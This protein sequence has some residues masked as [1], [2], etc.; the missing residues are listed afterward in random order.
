MYV[1]PWLLNPHTHL[2]EGPLIVPLVALAY[3]GGARLLGP[4]PNT[5]EGLLTGTSTIKYCRQGQQFMPTKEPIVFIPIVQLTE[6]TTFEMIDEWIACGVH[7]AKVY[8]KARTTGSHLGVTDY[9][10]IL[11][12]VRYCGEKGVR[13]H[14]HPELPLKNV[15][16]RDA[17]YLF[18]PVMDMF[19]RGTNTVLIWEHGTDARCIPYWKEWA[20]T[21]RFY[22]TITAHHLVENETTSY[23]DA[24]TACKPPP[25]TFADMHGLIALVSECHL[26]VM[27][28]GDDAPHSI[29][30]K[31]RV[32]QCACGA[33]TA[34][35]LLLL[36]AHALKELVLSDRGVVF[37]RFI[38]GNA[39]D[40]YG[41]RLDERTARL[42]DVPFHIPLEYQAGPWRIRPFWA[43]R[44]LDFSFA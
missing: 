13:V 35:F 14:F 4:M 41:L 42:D 15:D 20:K 9:F 38:N 32:G 11:P 6:D 16:N 44:T 31:H 24:A 26:W 5:R 25:K 21:G 29:E 7:D 30:D 22:L 28:G 36:Y 8:P 34:P 19:V 27:A 39:K 23:G 12:Q 1:V 17:E 43:G 3:V 33:Y 2:R 18:V 40:L 37:E 10:N